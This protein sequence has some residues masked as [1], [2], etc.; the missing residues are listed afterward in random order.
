MQGDRVVGAA[1]GWANGDL[2]AAMRARVL[3]CVPETLRPALEAG[4]AAHKLMSGDVLPLSGTASR[5]IVTA[6]TMALM[7]Q[8]GT[9]TQSI[10]Q[11]LDEGAPFGAAVTG[12]SALVALVPAKVLVFDNR[13][14]SGL[15]PEAPGL[16]R[17]FAAADREEMRRERERLLMLGERKITTRLATLVL[18]RR[19][20]DD[21]TTMVD[22]P[23]SRSDLAAYLGAR[24]ETLSRAA[25]EL[26]EAGCL[27]FHD[28]GRVE[29]LNLER[30][31]EQAGQ[32][33]RRESPA[34]WM[35]YDI[36]PLRG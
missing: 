27:Q 9:G 36:R 28:R 10:V 22:V 34:G 30:L 1:K 29:I 6:G 35:D 14:L 20:W 26:R 16:E 13:S 21:D 15:L 3:Q 32:D 4:L 17:L 33:V 24:I 18:Q 2:A 11:I 25:T 7:A 5:G 12:E 31:Q 19:R 8:Y 23:L